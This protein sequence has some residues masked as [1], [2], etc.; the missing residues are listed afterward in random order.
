MNPTSTTMTTLSESPTVSTIT[1]PIVS[2]FLSQRVAA[3]CRKWY[4]VA[5]RLGTQRPF[6]QKRATLLIQALAALIAQRPLSLPEIIEVRKVVEEEMT[7]I[8]QSLLRLP[9]TTS[10]SKRRRQAKSDL[11]WLQLAHAELD[12]LET[13]ARS[14]PSDDLP[15]I[16]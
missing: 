4:Q 3:C 13:R 9:E 10:P 1:V 14:S 16:S 12:A 11:D 7:R 5:D 15:S 6:I 8:K 2:W